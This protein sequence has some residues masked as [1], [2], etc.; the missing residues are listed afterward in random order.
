MIALRYILLIT[1]ALHSE[2]L[3]HGLLNRNNNNCLTSSLQGASVQFHV[4]GLIKSS[5]S[6]CGCHYTIVF[7]FDLH[8]Y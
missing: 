3:D 4:V 2:F 5:S 8:N 7:P 6:S 1:N